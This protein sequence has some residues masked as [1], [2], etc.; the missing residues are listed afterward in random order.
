MQGEDFAAL[1]RAYLQRVLN[2]MRLRVSDEA[3][4]ADLTAATFERAFTKR[5]QLRNSDAFAAWL[6]RIARNELAQHYRRRIR[7]EGP[8]PLEDADGLMADD[9]VPEDAVARNEDLEQLLNALEL[10]SARE[11]EIIRLRF[12]AGLTNRSIARVMRL[13]ESNVAVILF[14]AIRKLRRVFD[15]DDR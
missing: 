3:L 15:L 1:Y 5:Q 11:Q 13:S 6:F 7:R 4:A 9:P 12:V 10:L 8:V 2:Y 14:R